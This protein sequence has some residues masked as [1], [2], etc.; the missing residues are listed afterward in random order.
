MMPR[1]PWGSAT[2][3]Q[4]FYAWT[5]PS[6]VGWVSAEPLSPVSAPLLCS[7]I[8]DIDDPPPKKKQPTNISDLLFFCG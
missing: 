2:C 6:T 5:E 8:P 1:F 3:G 7:L 4:Q